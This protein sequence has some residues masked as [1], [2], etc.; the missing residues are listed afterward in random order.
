MRTWSIT[1]TAA[2]IEALFVGLFL[3]A[4]REAPP[5][6]IILDLDATDVPLHG[7]QGPKHCF[8]RRRLAGSSTATTMLTAACRST[9]SAAGTCGRRGCAG[10]TSTPP[11]APW[12]RSPASSARSAATGRGCGSCCAPAAASPAR[13]SWPGASGTGWTSSSASPATPARLVEELV[14]GLAWAEEEASRTNRPARPGPARPGPALPR[15]PLVDA[16]QLVAPAARGRQGGV[17]PRRGQPA[18]RRHLAQAR[19]DRC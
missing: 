3:E 13:R 18:L 11:P 6:Q 7:H 16:R 8:G 4:H 10:P 5:R 17:D 15:L 2:A 12:R 9:S 14:I 19:R 1:V